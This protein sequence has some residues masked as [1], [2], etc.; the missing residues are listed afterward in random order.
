VHVRDDSNTGEMV[1]PEWMSFGGT[2]PTLGGGQHPAEVRT[3]AALLAALAT[4]AQQTWDY[5]QERIWQTCLRLAGTSAE[6]RG[7]MIGFAVEGIPIRPMPSQAR[8]MLP[9]VTPTAEGEG[10]GKVVELPAANRSVGFW[11]SERDRCLRALPPDPAAFDARVALAI[12]DL[13]MGR[14]RLAV[15]RF[16]RCRLE[17]PETRRPCSGWPWRWNWLGGRKQQSAPT[18]ECWKST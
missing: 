7:K 18:S 15:L 16:Q 4:V 6:R 9:V 2:E 13:Y 12:C 1:Q 17:R 14:P 5:A 8:V 10:D 3:V 11:Q